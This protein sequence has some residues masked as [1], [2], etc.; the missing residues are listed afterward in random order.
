[1]KIDAYRDIL[2]V[3]LDSLKGGLHIVVI[4]YGELC[5][6]VVPAFPALTPL[7]PTFRISTTFAKEISGSGPQPIT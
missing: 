4:D 6:P 2:R 5:V 7:P 1:M 3:A